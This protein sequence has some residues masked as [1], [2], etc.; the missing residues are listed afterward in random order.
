M[1]RGRLQGLIGK[2]RGKVTTKVMGGIQKGGIRKMVSK[3]KSS[4]A[5]YD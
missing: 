3:Q 2:E 4:K 5:G 1:P